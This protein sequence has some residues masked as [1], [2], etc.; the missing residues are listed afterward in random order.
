[1]NGKHAEIL[2]RAVTQKYE[3]DVEANKNLRLDQRDL[4]NKQA[5]NVAKRKKELI[6]ARGMVAEKHRMHESD[7]IENNKRI[8]TLKQIRNYKV[9]EKHAM[10]EKSINDFKSTLS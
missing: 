1:M 6:E 7:A 5:K 4:F 2:H 10:K 9:F 3:T 8:E